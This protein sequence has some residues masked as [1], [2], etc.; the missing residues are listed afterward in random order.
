VNQTPAERTA[1]AVRARLA[2]RKI[3]GRKLARDLG[4]NPTNTSRRINGKVPF[5]IN[6]L[7][8]VADYLDVPLVSLVRPDDNVAA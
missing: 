6:E 4:W 5:S 1:A 2:W 8:A 7:T 3:S